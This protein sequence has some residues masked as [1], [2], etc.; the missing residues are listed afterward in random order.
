M[1]GWLAG[2]ETIHPTDP[3]EMGGSPPPE[4]DII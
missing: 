2:V 3:F 1:P 4:I